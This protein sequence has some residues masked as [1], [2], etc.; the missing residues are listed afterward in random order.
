[1]SQWI[2]DLRDATKPGGLLE[3]LFSEA[4]Y[5]HQGLTIGKGTEFVS[6]GDDI[7]RQPCIETRNTGQQGGRG[8]IH[9]N[10]D[11]VYTILYN[12][13]QGSGQFALVNVM[14][15]LADANRF[16]LNLDQF[17][18]WILKATGDGDRPT[19]TDIQ[20]R[21]FLGCQL[22]RGVHRGTG[23]GDHDAGQAELGVQLLQIG[24]Q[25][26][27]FPRRRPITDCHQLNA[28]A[29]RQGGQGPQAA[30]TIA[31][32]FERI[33]GGGIQHLAGGVD[34][35]DFDSGTDARVQ[36]QNR[37]GSGRGGQKQI[38]Q[39]GGKNPNGFFFCRFAQATDE[40]SL[41]R[42]QELHTPGPAAYL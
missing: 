37:L 5:F 31:S 7:A 18:Q 2:D 27:S 39:V 26:F 38:F 16:G 8:R 3:G 29:F 17:R 21:K 22:G 40:L 20:I 12:G 28:M 15:I 4:G 10:T 9:V 42:G 25:L 13:V 1:T 6:E 19:Q 32:R 11:R 24:Y 30:F 35:A 41:E 36:P 14:L 23:F 33:N 34:R